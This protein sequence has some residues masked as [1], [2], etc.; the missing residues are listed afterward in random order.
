MT[1]IPCPHSLA[2]IS[3]LR[4]GAEDFVDD[5]LRR[6]TYLWAY[7][8]MLKSLNRR[9]MWGKVRSKRM[10]PLVATYTTIA[11]LAIAPIGPL[12]SLTTTT[13]K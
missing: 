12:T 13:N 3:Q 11:T 2:C 5:S 10:L 8:F 6:T 4:R 1:N 9:R 7:N